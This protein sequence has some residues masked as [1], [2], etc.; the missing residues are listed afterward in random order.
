MYNHIGLV[1]RLVRDPEY[2]ATGNGTS[3]CNFTLAVD[4]DFKN[5]SGEKETDFIDCVAWRQSAEFVTNYLRKGSMAAVSGRLQIRG[6][7]DKDGNRRKTA[8]VNCDN[9]YAVGSRQDSN[10]NG[11]GGNSQTG[12]RYGAPA[13]YQQPTGYGQSDFA[14]IDD[15]DAN[16]PF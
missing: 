8:E 14:Q 10:Q 5:Q 12:A 6:W 2:R 16:L 15:D 4:R 1:G 9:V 7:T 13:G 3:V 11:G